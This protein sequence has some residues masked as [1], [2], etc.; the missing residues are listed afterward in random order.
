MSE[1]DDA[2]EY[3]IPFWAYSDDEDLAD[4]R[5]DLAAPF[6][7]EPAADPGGLGLSDIEEAEAEFRAWW[8]DT[9]AAQPASRE[10]VQKLLGLPCLSWTGCREAVETAS[11]FGAW[12]LVEQAALRALSVAHDGDYKPSP[13]LGLVARQVLVAK[14]AE[15]VLTDLAAALADGQARLRAVLDN[16]R[17]QGRT[18]VA[19]AVDGEVRLASKMLL[20]LGSPDDASA[21]ASL[22]GGLRRLGRPDLA[23]ET[24]TRAI[25][26]QPDNRAAWVVRAAARADRRNH[27]GALADLDQD[28]LKDDIAAAVTKIRVLRTIGRLKQALA[29]ALTTAQAKPSKYAL[30]MLRLLAA[31]TGDDT[32]LAVAERLFEGTGGS[33]DRPPSRLLGLLAAEQLS[34]DG[35][36]DNALLLAEVVAAEGP[37][38]QRAET[39]LRKLRR[40]AA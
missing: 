35:D 39:L 4:G 2:A 22:A 31:Q 16:A 38:W 20:L 21:L 34:R 37:P 40:E 28:M 13:T 27:R 15:A 32:A 19:D 25:E 24:A 26:L 3:G 33:P 23:E 12:D 8:A 1:H 17:R 10:T 7:D 36:H 29:L 30:T 6:W 11:A 5:G 14:C 9:I 18:A